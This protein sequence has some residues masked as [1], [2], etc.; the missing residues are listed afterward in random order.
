MVNLF[1]LIFFL[2]K[3]FFDSMTKFISKWIEL[4]MK[5]ERFYIKKNNGKGYLLIK[6][7]NSFIAWIDIVLVNYQAKGEGGGT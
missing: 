6:R 1:L 7:I 2:I 5:L 3:L 4:I